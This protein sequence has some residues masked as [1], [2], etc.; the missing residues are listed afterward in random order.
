M[1]ESAFSLVT[2]GGVAVIICVKLCGQVVGIMQVKL[3]TG[4]GFQFLDIICRGRQCFKFATDVGGP[5]HTRNVD[6][7]VYHAI[8]NLVGTPYQ[9]YVV[10]HLML[11]HSLGFTFGGFMRR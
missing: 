10:C 6:D 7:E 3:V 8:E 4:S 11:P 9:L 2:C 1:Q 5:H